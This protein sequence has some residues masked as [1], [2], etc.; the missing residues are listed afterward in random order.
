[1]RQFIVFFGLNLL[2][3]ARLID[4]SNAESFDDVFEFNNYGQLVYGGSHM[5]N[6]ESTVGV[7]KSVVRGPGKP[8]KI[9]RAGGKTKIPR[10]FLF[11]IYFA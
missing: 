9:N 1:M 7:G 10:V 11:V 4:V 2:L 6:I 3:I 8:G 5:S